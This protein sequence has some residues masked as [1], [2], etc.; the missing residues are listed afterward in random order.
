LPLHEAGVRR[1]QS[2]PLPV[3]SPGWNAIGYV[4]AVSEWLLR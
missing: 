3:G 4:S 1:R 2:P